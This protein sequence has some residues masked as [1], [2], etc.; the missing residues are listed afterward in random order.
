MM[1]NE[2]LPRGFTA[3]PSSMEDLEAVTRLINTCEIAV[4]GESE[5]SLDEVC[6]AWQMPDFHFETDTRV[7]FSPEGE[8]VGAVDVGHRQYARA[9]MFGNV[10]PNY[11]GRG[12]GTYL[13]HVAEQRSQQFIP[14]AAPDARVSLGTGVSSK[15]QATQRLL[16]DNGFQP[17]RHFWRMGI[18]LDGTTPAAQWAEGLTLQTMAPGTERTL[19]EVDE[20]TFRDHWGHIPS[21][22]EEWER[23]MVKRESFDPSL[24]FLAMDGNQIAGFA[25]CHNEKELGGW[26]NVLGVRRAWRRKGI[27]LAL[28][29]HAFAEFYRR[30][31]QSVYLGVDAQSLTGATRLYERAGMHVVKDNIRYEKE[32]RAGRELSTQSVEV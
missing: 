30:G 22:F 2:L 18:D 17:V 28:L 16:E 10:H 13:L 23:W 27:G 8:C 11:Q 1:I 20:E 21:T 3:R 12:I 31:V 32:L 4:D 9:H 5:T 25:F 24:Y 26:V 7:V 15:D 29:Y 19:F 6:T 14:H